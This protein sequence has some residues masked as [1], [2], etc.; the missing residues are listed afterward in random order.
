VSY[1]PPVLATSFV[2]SSVYT[3]KPFSPVNLSFICLIHRL[4]ELNLTEWRKSLSPP[5]HTMHS[6]KNS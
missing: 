1:R 5:L 2:N 4:Q 6:L 3:N